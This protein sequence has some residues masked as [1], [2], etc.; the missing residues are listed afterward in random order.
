MLVW[1]CKAYRRPEAKTVMPLDVQHQ[2][3]MLLERYFSVAKI[4]HEMECCFVYL[5]GQNFS[6]SN[7]GESSSINARKKPQLLFQ[8][9]MAR[10][11]IRW[12]GLSEQPCA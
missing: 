11:S 6:H 8:H 1:D 4:Q 9:A 5:E 3:R 12:T 2:A 10:V 7:S